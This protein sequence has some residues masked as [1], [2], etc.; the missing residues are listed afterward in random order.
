MKENK[1]IE[2]DIQTEIF[3][4]KNIKKEEELLLPNSNIIKEKYIE[5]N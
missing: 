4:Q 2:K 1:I 3:S 5:N